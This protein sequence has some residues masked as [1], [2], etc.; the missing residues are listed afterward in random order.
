MTNY[1]RRY[2]SLYSTTLSTS[3][4]TGTGET[5]TF[6]SVTNVPTDTEITVTIDRVDSSGTATASKME[7][8]TGTLS[9]SNLTSY[10]RG[11]DN[12]TEQAHSAGAVVEMVWNAADWNAA[13]AGFLVE[14]GQ[15]GAHDAGF[16]VSSYFSASSI[17]S[18]AI[19]ASAVT[20]GRIGASAVVSGN[21]AASSVVTGNLAA[22]SVLANNLAASSILAGN[23]SAS[24]IVLGNLAASSVSSGNLN[25]A[26]SLS[27]KIIASTRDLTAV[28]GNVAYTG[29][30]FQPTAIIAFANVS[31]T[32]NTSWGMSDS[33]MTVRDINGIQSA[34]VHYLNP[35]FIYLPV[36]V[37]NNQS[38]VIASYDADGFTLTWTKTNSPT[39]T[40]TLAFLCFR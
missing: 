37:T 30:G 22:S 19:N 2:R 16:L 17:N 26:S 3:I 12:S 9:G 20:S 13:I 5:I 29:V 8:I 15:T 11:A 36:D 33:S 27:S 25:F 24:A 32:S 7:R 1:F 6:A 31:G 21:L 10:V 38:A 23:L 39:G 28:S 14:H 4:S 18:S 40:G 34:T 35:N